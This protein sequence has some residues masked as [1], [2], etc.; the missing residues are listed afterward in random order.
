MSLCPRHAL[1]I[2]ANYSENCALCHLIARLITRKWCGQLLMCATIPDD[3]F[4]EKVFVLYVDNIDRASV[5]I[6]G[7]DAPFPGIRKI[8]SAPKKYGGKR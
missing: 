2:S 8:P 6:R 5:S 1:L 4:K 3:F 7:S